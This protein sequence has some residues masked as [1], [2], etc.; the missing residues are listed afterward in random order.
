M[1]TIA[2]EKRLTVGG[3]AVGLV[4]D[5]VVLELGAV[6]FGVFHVR[7]DPGDT[8]KAV[9]RLAVGRRGSGVVYPVLEGLVVEAAPVGAQEWRL[10]VR[11]P[12]IALDLPAAFALRHVTPAHALAQIETDTGLRFALPESGDYLGQRQAHF[13]AQGTH[14]QALDAMGAAWGVPRCVW[15]TLADG[16][17]YWGDWSASP[18]ATV[19]PLQLDPRIVV[20][21][22]P[23]A[24]TIA[25]PYLPR[26]RPGVV[27]ADAFPFMVRRVE[28]AGAT[29]RLEW[30]DVG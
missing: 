28:L 25:L 8:Q 26:L 21:R 19:E 17:I 30:G 3:A 1:T 29:A 12:A 24:R 22:D 5:R 23:E 27:V 6:G 9:A 2:L 20:E 18:F 4:S 15:A 13:I 14:R 11:E 16:S 7:G 10:V